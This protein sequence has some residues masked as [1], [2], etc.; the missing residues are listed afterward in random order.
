MGVYGGPSEPIMDF[1]FRRSP[2]ATDDE[3]LITFVHMSNDSKHW[4]PRTLQWKCPDCGCYN[5]LKSSSTRHI[6]CDQILGLCRFTADIK[7]EHRHKRLVSS[8]NM[9]FFVRSVTDSASELRGRAGIL[10]K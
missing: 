10:Q 7:N 4:P 5:V 9:P 6:E 3:V 1:F 8:Q 2:K